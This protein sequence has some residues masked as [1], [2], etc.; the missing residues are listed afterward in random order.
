MSMFTESAWNRQETPADIETAS[1][2]Y[3]ARFRGPAGIWMLDVQSKAVRELL[4]NDRISSILEVGGGHGQLT[5]S[6]VQAGYQVTVHGSAASC[7]RGIS[8]LL[9]NQR[10]QFVVGSFLH[11]PFGD[12]SFDAVV[13]V[14]L[15]MHSDEWRRLV[16]EMCRVARQVVVVDYPLMST[17]GQRFFGAKKRLE[18]NTRPWRNFRHDEVAAAFQNEGFVAAG[19]T[20]QFFFPMVLHRTLQQ[21]RVSGALEG[22]ARCLGLHRLRGSPVMARFDR[23]TT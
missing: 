16:G 22:I 7:Q 20:G 15:I 9:H 1:E 4:P 23:K 18:K 3:A 21:R 19:R 14:R 11:L 10:C 8:D 12:R 6:L 13:C 17:L 2:G 5:P